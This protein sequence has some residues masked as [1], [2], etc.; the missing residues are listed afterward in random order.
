M[1]I[2]KEIA[3][4]LIKSKEA[5]LVILFPVY[6]EKVKEGELVYKVRLVG[7]ERTHYCALNTYTATPSREELFIMLHIIMLELAILSCR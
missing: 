4:P 6:E 3:L 2:F 7:D 1:Q 5:D